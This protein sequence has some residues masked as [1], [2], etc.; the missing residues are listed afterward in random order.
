MSH[1]ENTE[2]LWPTWPFSWIF[3]R[4]C[5]TWQPDQWTS[6]C[7][8]S[9]ASSSFESMGRVIKRGVFKCWWWI[10]PGRR[11]MKLDTVNSR[12]GF[13]WMRGVSPW[14]G[15]KAPK[16]FPN[17]FFFY[18]LPAQSPAQQLLHSSCPP[19]NI[20]EWVV[21]Q[22]DLSPFHLSKWSVLPLVVPTH[23]FSMSC[24]NKQ[25]KNLH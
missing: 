1:C 5:N 12:F 9:F 8:P 17:S 4:H 22:A 2:N 14:P 13:P 6:C 19:W 3:L 15:C 18:L 23:I 10:G 16:M 11:Y 7:F 21:H 25:T 24:Q 20:L